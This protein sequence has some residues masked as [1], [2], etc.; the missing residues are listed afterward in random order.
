MANL[1]AHYVVNANSISV[2]LRLSAQPAQYDCVA[3]LI[4]RLPSDQYGFAHTGKTF[5]VLS[6]A[7]TC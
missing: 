1:V 7:T 5:I 2:I 3:Y 6:T 4:R